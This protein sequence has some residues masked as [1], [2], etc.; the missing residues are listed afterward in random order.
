MTVFPKLLVDLEQVAGL[1]GALVFLICK[2]RIIM[3]LLH[4]LKNSIGDGNFKPVNTILPFFFFPL[5][6][7]DICCPL[8]DIYHLILGTLKAF[9]YQVNISLMMGLEPTC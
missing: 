9:K 4:F 3:D 1:H 7:L 5:T 2:M 8:K 6:A